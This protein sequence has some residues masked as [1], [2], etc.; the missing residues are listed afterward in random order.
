[1]IQRECL[2]IISALKPFRHCLLGCKFLLLTNHSPLQWISSQKM[3][4]LLARWALATQEYD[5]TITYRKGTENQNVSCQF[6][7]DVKLQQYH[8]PIICQL[9]EAL[10]HCSVP[11]CTHAWSQCPLSRY[12][13]LWQQL[14]IKD[15]LVCRH[16][17][18]GP[19]S[20]PL[21]VPII[22]SSYQSTLL[23]Q[24]HDHPAAGHLRA[25]KLQQKSDKWLL[26]RY[27]T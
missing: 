4:G 13:Q 6:I 8:D 20:E 11:P 2:A 24:H 5:F 1:M 19:T 12:R 23:H 3:E 9:Y 26:G 7:E 14:L 27:A 16:Y 15:G 21:T 22:L 25:D 10:S 18:P 17:T